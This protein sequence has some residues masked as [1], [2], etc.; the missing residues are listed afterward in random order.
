[1][2][3]KYSSIEAVSNALKAKK[4]NPAANVFLL[5]QETKTYGKWETLYKEAREHG[6]IFLR[7]DKAHPPKLADGILSVFDMILNDEL[8]IKPDLLVLSTPMLPA[9]ENEEL[10][11]LFLV[12]LN[13]YGF[14][15]E[16][17][18][19]PK[20]V[21]T[22]VDT[23]N[24]GVFICGSAVYPG[25]VDETLAMS[26]AAA[27]RA[28]V[29]LAKNFLETPGIVSVV[30]EEICS[31]CGVCVELCPV[32]AIE[33]IEEPVSAVTY[34]IMTVTGGKRVY[35]HVTE[36]CIGCGSCASLCPSS[37][38]SLKS[39]KDRQMFAQVDFA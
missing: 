36:G 28:S 27:A 31:G 30:D 6:V 14:F 12:P 2:P 33:L 13:R 4:K 1:V 23:V 29:I 34:G 10:S 8:Q 7:Y 26:S 11:K 38:M 9:E 18:E 37:A 22:P 32:E 35:A 24:E 15:M 19:R 21:L 16:E 5:Y 25:M 17:Q 39:F 20:L 3:S